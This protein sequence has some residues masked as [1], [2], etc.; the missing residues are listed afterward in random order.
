[1]LIYLRSA[2]ASDQSSRTLSSP[3]SLGGSC[4][5]PLADS[6]SREVHVRECARVH[7]KRGERREERKG[8]GL[9]RNLKE[10]S[11]WCVLNSSRS[12]LE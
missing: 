3:S 2:F 10:T 5:P 7:R 4:P 6:N 9:H 8:K 12:V 11:E 1:M